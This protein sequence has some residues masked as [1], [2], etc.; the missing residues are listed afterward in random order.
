MTGAVRK[1]QT[2]RIRALSIAGH[3]YTNLLCSLLPNSGST[4]HLGLGFFRRHV[5]TIDFAGS[6]MLLKRRATFPRDDEDDL[7]GLHLI[8]REGAAVVYAVDKESAA[9]KAGFQTGDELT[10]IDARPTTTL[11]MRQI[12]QIFKNE[13]TGSLEVSVK[14]DGIKRSFILG[15]HP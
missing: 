14:R 9:A 12:R 10:E 5:L 11:S 13:A 8:R 2:A 15:A 4:S 6:R 1:S 3:E 7:S